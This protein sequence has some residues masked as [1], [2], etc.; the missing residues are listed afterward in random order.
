MNKYLK[1]FVAARITRASVALGEMALVIRDAELLI[2]VGRS[3]LL[4]CVYEF[5][6]VGRV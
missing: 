6:A 3:C 4:L 2:S 5:A 1:H